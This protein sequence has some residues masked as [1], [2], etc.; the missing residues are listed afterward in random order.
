M[1]GIMKY[2]VEMCS[3]AMKYVTNLINIGSKLKSKSKL[4][5]DRRL[6]LPVRLGIKHPAEA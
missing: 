2:A 5:Y 3:S 6:S 4:C 1:E